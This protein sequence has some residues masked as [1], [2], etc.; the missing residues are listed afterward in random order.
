MRK[1]LAVSIAAMGL[2]LC[3]AGGVKADNTDS[4]AQSYQLKVQQKR[5]RNALKMQQ[6][7][8][9]R[10]WRNGHTTATNRSQMKHSMARDSRNLKLRQKDARQDLKD[11]QR[12]VKDMQR[13]YN[14]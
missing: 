3:Q 4:R 7:N 9:K 11:R 2:V 10:S 13:G 1:I 6:Q 14:Q 5:E 12:S 8:V